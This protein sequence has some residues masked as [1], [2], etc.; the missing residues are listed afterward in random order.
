MTAVQ[1]EIRGRVGLITLNRPDRL[2]ALTRPM[3]DEIM[4][5]MRKAEA[6]PEV[7]AIAV[8]GA[9]RGFCA[10]LD[11]EALVEA[12]EKGLDR[13]PAD[14]NDDQLPGLFI[15][16][17]RISKPVI[18]AVN[19]PAAGAGFVLAMMSDLRFMADGAIM[20]TVFS[21]RGLIAEH[22]T[23]W[24]LPR[25]VGLSRALDLLWSSRKV[26]AD[27]ALRIGLA[28]RVCAPDELLNAVV[29]YV[30]ELAR[31]VSPRS[32]AVMKDQVYRH[33]S[34][35][36]PSAARE[37]DRLIRESLAHPDSREGA[38]SFVERRDP[39]FARWTGAEG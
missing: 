25:M 4:D 5:Q 14:P 38:R 33:M 37:T 15:D 30:E 10:G 29:A 18:A 20:T 24:I 8:T 39:A 28:D 12:T 32:L 7:F 36:L 9:G 1:F 13:P 23:S 11:A 27:E 22:Q 35:D 26:G 17:P 3:I 6:D 19:G 2:N 34:D 16:L 21:K 31:T